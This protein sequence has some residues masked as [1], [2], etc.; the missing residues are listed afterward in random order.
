MLSSQRSARMEGEDRVIVVAEMDVPTAHMPDSPFWC[1]QRGCLIYVCCG[2]KTV[3][4]FTPSKETDCSDS[5][6]D[7]ESTVDSGDYLDVMTMDQLVGFAIPTTSCSN[8]TDLLLLVGL[9]DRVVEV[10]FT[11]KTVIRTIAIVRESVVGMRFTNGKCSPDGTLIAVYNHHWSDGC[12]KGKVYVLNDFGELT[13]ILH[14]ESL[15]KPQGSAWYLNKIYYLVDGRGNKI[16]RFNVMDSD[17]SKVLTEKSTVF[18]L[19][20]TD[21]SRHYRMCGM[22]IDS[23][24]HL[25]VAV[26]GAS[27]LI[28]IDAD[29]GMELS[30]LSLPCKYPTSCV[31]GG[32][33]LRDLYITCKKQDSE[34]E[35]EYG[36][37]IASGKLLIAR[38]R[39]VKGLSGGAIALVPNKEH[40]RSNTPDSNS[41]D[42]RQNEQQSSC[43]GLSHYFSCT[44]SLLQLICAREE[45]DHSLTSD[46]TDQ[47]INRS[48][49]DC[50]E[51]DEIAD[52]LAGCSILCEIA[53]QGLKNGLAGSTFSTESWPSDNDKADKKIHRSKSRSR[54]NISFKGHLYDDE[55]QKYVVFGGVHTPTI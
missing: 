47:Q 12:T 26:S 22:D 24:G 51:S 11:E 50:S 27:C 40:L 6:T 49:S 19:S 30:R 4:V 46:A 41:L 37:N 39:E 8:K 14:P 13:T 1:S 31:F 16:Y 43:P 15:L 2:L 38:L 34:S 42:K 54:R 17:G 53:G 28:R 10:N 29:R 32:A 48:P 35:N 36:G 18:E 3:Y 25:W 55:E 21:V 45:A 5:T 52:T 7:S 23:E 44:P 20:E 33:S 9:E